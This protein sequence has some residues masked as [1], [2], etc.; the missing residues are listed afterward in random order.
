M[1]KM[2][3][4]TAA[5]TRK[6]TLPSRV[7]KVHI[8][9]VGSPTRHCDSAEFQKQCP[10]PKDA[11]VAHDVADVHLGSLPKTPFFGVACVPAS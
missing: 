8:N 10:S 11:Q 7:S 5:A 1:S 4:A 9:A 3:P 2:H 6:A